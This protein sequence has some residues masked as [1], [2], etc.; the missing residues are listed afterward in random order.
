MRSI[1]RYLVFGAVVVHFGCTEIETPA[2]QPTTVQQFPSSEGTNA[3]TV[4]LTE[5][6]VTTRIQSAR[7]ISFSD[8]DSAWAYKLVVDFYNRLG[9]HSSKLNADSALVR[10]KA[11]LLEGFGNVRIVTDDGRTLE[12]QHLA[13][14]DAARLITTDSLVTITR[15]EDVMRG[16][17]FSSDPELTR[18][19]LRNQVSGRIT[20]TDVIQD[21]L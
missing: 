21:S 19:R 3:T 8:Q 9:E 11:R 14:D 20:D 7:V 4:F 13:W 16:Y 12:S 2:P 17:G 1:S 18:I 6:I 10:E 15:D 5:S